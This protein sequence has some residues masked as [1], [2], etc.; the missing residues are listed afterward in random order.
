MIVMAILVTILS[1]AI[2]FYQAALIRA[3]ES[4]LKSNL[5]TIRSVIDQYT[6]DKEQPPQSLPG[7]NSRLISACEVYTLSCIEQGFNWPSGLTTRNL[8]PA[9]HPLISPFSKNS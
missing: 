9:L 7:T 2:P 6:Y 5:F 4:V 1:I 8:T 3:K